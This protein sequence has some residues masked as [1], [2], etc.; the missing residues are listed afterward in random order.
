MISDIINFEKTLLEYLFI[1]FL[2][3]AN[4][5]RVIVARRGWDGLREGRL[6]ANIWQVAP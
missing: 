4:L 3:K 1:Y 5:G 6:P 2:K